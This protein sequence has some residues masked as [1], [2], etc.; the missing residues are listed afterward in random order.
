M[1]SGISPGIL[2]CLAALL[3]P[4][5]PGKLR[6]AWTVLVPLLSLIDLVLLDQGTSGVIDMGAVTLTT[7]RL[8]QTAF[9]F[10]LLFHVALLIGSI[11][12]W[13]VDD[14][15]QQVAAMIYGGG[16]IGAALAGDM[17]T[18]F[19]FWEVIAVASVFLI[20]A[21]RTERAY[22]AG[23]RYLIWQIVSGVLL[24]AGALMIYRDSG[25]LVFDKVGLAD[26]SGWLILLAFGIKA[27]FPLVHIWLVDA[28]P[29]ATPT[30]T[31]FLSA[32]TTKLAVYALIRAFAGE[33]VLI[34][35]GSIMAIFPIFYAVIEDDLRRVLSYSMINQVGFM[36]VGVGL[37]SEFGVSGAMAHAYADV[38]FKGLLFM[39]MGAVLHRTGKVA[40]SELG[41]LYKTM[42]YTTLCCLIGALSISAFPLFSAF[43]TTSRSVDGVAEE[44]LT[45]VWFILVFASAGVLH[46]AGIKIPFFAFFAHDQGLR[47]T[48]APWGM[49]IA[50]GL[51]A[52]LCIAV[53]VY[54]WALY[55]LLPLG[56][57]QHY[58]PYTV[59]H[60]VFQL[61][62]LCFAI[63]A[64]VVLMVTHKHPPETP[65]TNLDADW[66]YRGPL[67]RQLRGV[68]T[69]PLAR[70]A[71]GFEHLALTAAPARIGRLFMAPGPDG[72]RLA[73]SWAMGS[74]VFAFLFL[75]AGWLL[76]SGVTS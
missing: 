10:A 69:G 67:K 38:V 6:A 31:V 43:A 26:L 50:M 42:P 36:V 22:A 66:I 35:V 58:Q 14:P 15:V 25:S 21:Q 75:L 56:E 12:A 1:V 61:Q 17:I 68:F 44:H 72:G 30:G 41:G 20:W 4:L 74:S 51:S 28:Y 76:W 34:W 11:Y 18:L 71:K 8:D 53:G 32:F 7:L 24:L 29:E 39:T 48:E 27:G 70:L 64:F 55:G 54:P 5:L 73:R 46:H 19:V 49:R 63:L 45:G 52:F 16:A 23:Q 40:A 59:S 33:G 47:T 60:V 57:V 13:H 65:G 62:I 3:I 2:I 9:F 37:G